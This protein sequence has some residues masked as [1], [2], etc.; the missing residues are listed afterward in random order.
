MSI[1]SKIQEILEIRFNPAQITVTDDSHL[2]ADHNSAAAAGG[3][4][5]SVVIVSDVFTGKSLV[6]RHRMV[7]DA[8][9]DE[10]KNGIHAL[11]IKAL[12]SKEKIGT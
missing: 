1:K 9:A 10:I 11:A 4:H 6:G 7:Y 2:H 12:T 3:T 5:F 8:L